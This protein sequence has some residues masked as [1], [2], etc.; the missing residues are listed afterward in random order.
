MELLIRFFSKTNG[1]EKKDA[2]YAFVVD[3]ELTSE[4]KRDLR[5]KVRD[6]VHKELTNETH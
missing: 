5:H 3:G 4:Q 1:Q 6:L 2:T